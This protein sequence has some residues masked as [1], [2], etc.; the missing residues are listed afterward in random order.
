MMNQSAK[1]SEVATRCDERRRQASSRSN[2]YGLLTL[3]FRDV[4]TPEVVAGLRDPPLAQ[5]FSDFGYDV[6]KDLAGD[7]GAVTEQLREDYTRVFVA[8]GPHVS[9][10]G[11]VHHK[12]EG[13]LWGNSTV[14][15]KRFIEATGLS[16]QGNWDSIPDHIAVGLELMQ[17]LIAREAELWAQRATAPANGEE[18]LDARLGRC[19]RLEEKF[20]RDYLCNWVPQFCDRVVARSA[21]LFYQEMAGLTKSL[22]LSDI[23]QMEGARSTL[24]HNPSAG[25]RRHGAAEKP[26]PPREAGSLQEEGP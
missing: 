23:E 14:W 21:T 6:A 26:N 18:K 20:L 15:A 8:P 12:N 17:R 10:Y 9:P 4:P 11:S 3:I 25:P 19:L 2:C 22:L 24:R 16:F 13:G 5:A 7:L 1:A